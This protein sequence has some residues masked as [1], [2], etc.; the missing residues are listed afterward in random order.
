MQLRDQLLV[1]MESFPFHV[2][3]EYEYVPPFVSLVK[4][5]VTHL[6]ISSTILDKRGSNSCLNM[7]PRGRLLLLLHPVPTKDR[8]CMLPLS[9]NNGK[10]I[11]P[12]EVRKDDLV[13]PSMTHN[14]EQ[15]PNGIH[16]YSLHVDDLVP[17]ENI[18]VIM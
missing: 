7:F 14:P 10:G 5:L 11:D 3:I 13:G 2:D 15:E 8:M 4:L 17:N 12:A 6:I 16:I 18:L 9:L 1:E